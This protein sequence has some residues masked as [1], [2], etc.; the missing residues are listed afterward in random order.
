MAIDLDPDLWFDQIGD[1]TPNVVTT[2][3]AGT[4]NITIVSSDGTNGIP[5][6]DLTGS[7][8]GD[9]SANAARILKAILDYVYTY[10]ESLA[11]ADKPTTMVTTRSSSAS[12]STLYMTYA[13]RFAIDTPTAEV[14]DE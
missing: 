11:T 2:G 7:G 6:L 13:V 8:D 14:A 4:G 9:D 5:G 10:Q 12:G 3:V 1:S